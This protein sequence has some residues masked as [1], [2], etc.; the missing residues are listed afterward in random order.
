[1]LRPPDTERRPNAN[2]FTLGSPSSTRHASRLCKSKGRSDDCDT[3]NEPAGGADGRKYETRPAAMERPR[4]VAW[5]I[6]VIADAGLLVW[7][8]MAAMAP[9]I[10][11]IGYESFTG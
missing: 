6:I 4:R 5:L 1:T 3:T 2:L 9:D 8:A 11:R 7:G 10:L